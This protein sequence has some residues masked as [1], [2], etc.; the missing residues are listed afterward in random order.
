MRPIMVIAYHE[1]EINYVGPCM[2][3]TKDDIVQL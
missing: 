3:S 2:C 1:K